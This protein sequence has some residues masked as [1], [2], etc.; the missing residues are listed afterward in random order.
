MIRKEQM[1]KRRSN[2]KAERG[3]VKTSINA[4]VVNSQKSPVVKKNKVSPGALS[5]VEFIIGHKTFDVS[6][7]EQ[8]DEISVWTVNLEWLNASL[9]GEIHFPLSI[10]NI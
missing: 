2:C 5:F 9:V 7:L 3:E 1:I 8:K 6:Q 4:K 10:D